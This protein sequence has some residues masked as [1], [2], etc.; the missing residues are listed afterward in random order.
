MSEDD[1]LDTLAKA[2]VGTTLRGKYKLERLLGVGGM[3][4]VYEASH[5]VGTRVAVKVLHAHASI[6]SDV[7]ARFLREGYV[8]NQVA[9]DGAVR[10]LDDDTAEDG[11]VFL[12]MELLEG[13]TLDARLQRVKR[14]P[15]RDV[16]ELGHQL[17]DALAAAHGKGIVHRDIK[18][19]NLFVTDKGT[20]KI[21]DFGIARLVTSTSATATQTGRVLGSPA[22]MAP[23]QALGKQK[24]IDARTDLWSVGATMF[25]LMSGVFVHDAE[26][27]EELLVFAGSRSARK[28]R[29]VAPEVPLPLAAVVDRALEFDRERRWESAAAMEAALAAAYEEVFGATVPL[30]VRTSASA[31][32]AS[33]GKAPSFEPSTFAP[34]LDV[35]A[36]PSTA[37]TMASPT[38]RAASTTAGVDSSPRDQA[39][40][41]RSPA[42]KSRTR[43]V[44][45]AGAAV[46][47]VGGVAAVLG[48]S[49]KAPLALPSSVARD[50]PPR[51]EQSA[52]VATA[53]PS[54]TAE[55]QQAV[56]ASASTVPVTTVLASHTARHPVPSASVSA[57]PKTPKPNCDPNYTLD[58][59]GNKIFKP[60]CFQ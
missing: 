42:K 17:L 5:R 34:T 16:A 24:V 58:S 44:V 21:L 10:V 13:E 14:L 27:V 36:V 28:L 51:V 41:T 8:A 6:N 1:A 12:A 26:S 54:A 37:Q 59:E 45:A 3:A 18:P 15:V 46:L 55:R 56:P 2:R 22:F 30:T 57:A 49:G 31:S 53:L 48:H 4:A 20:L 29:E 33:G 50:T 35:R 38:A 11:S 23:E 7:R 52:G 43:L 47:A 9:H 19:E 40:P 32:N 60:E 39:R 25:T